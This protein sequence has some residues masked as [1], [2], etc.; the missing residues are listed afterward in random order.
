VAGIRTARVLVG[1]LVAGL[2]INIGETI[3]NIPLA[4]AALEEALKSRN[5][6]PIGGGAIAYFVI[7]CFLLGIVM[8]WTY[9]A[10]RPRLGAGPK[11]A[12]IVGALAWF[13]TLAWS[14]GSQVA[15]GIMPLKLTVL[16]LA[17]GLG[18]MMIASLAGAKL[19]R[20]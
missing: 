8:V 12:L 17:W 6:P 15:M 5:L 18:E 4:G 20:E 10:I 16:G 11:T 2:I 3:L 14:G 9:A 13:M 7:M 19:Y 1:G